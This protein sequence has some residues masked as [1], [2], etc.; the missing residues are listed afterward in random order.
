MTT[1]DE[2]TYE[3]I[4]NENDAR[5]CAQL[6]AEEF[7]S[8]NP[9][10]I[11]D[12]LTSQRMFD[13]D[14]WPFMMEVLDERLSFLARHRHSGEIVA[15][16]CGC[17]L[18]LDH[19]RHPYDPSSA[20]SS[21]TCFDLLDEM[22]DIFIHRDFGQELKPNVVLKI[23][24]GATRAEHSGKSVGTQLR[25]FMCKY[26]R[27]T[28]KFQY[29]LAQTTNQA[30]RHIYVNKMGGKEL[31]IIDPKTWIWKKKDDRLCPYKDYSGGPVPNI[32]IKL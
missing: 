5:I 9:I 8:H 23:V 31:T 19:E 12:Q 21:I 3:V 26:A 32:L 25:T 13:E 7:V 30:T 6:L 14:T 22:D 16:I 20:P 1:L 2:Y 28:R 4:D 29:A 17:D 27:D 15:T 10:I 18:Y 24:M 11:C